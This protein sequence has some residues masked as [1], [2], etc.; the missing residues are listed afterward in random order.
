MPLRA[1]L[2]ELMDAH[3]LSPASFSS[4]NTSFIPTEGN[5]SPM[6]EKV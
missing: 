3:P 6:N 2:S 4:T 5:F 1:F